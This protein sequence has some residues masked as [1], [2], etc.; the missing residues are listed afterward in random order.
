MEATEPHGFQDQASD[1]A[2]LSESSQNRSISDDEKKIND[3]NAVCPKEK[4]PDSMTSQSD[5]KSTQ[6][7]RKLTASRAR[8]VRTALTVYC[9]VEPKTTLNDFVKEE[10]SVETFNPSRTCVQEIENFEPMKCVG[11]KANDRRQDQ[12]ARLLSPKNRSLNVLLQQHANY[13]L[14][15]GCQAVNSKTSSAIPISS[16]T[17]RPKN[18]INLKED[19]QLMMSEQLLPK[20]DPDENK[21]DQ[22]R[23]KADIYTDLQGEAIEKHLKDLLD[24]YKG[25]F[26]TIGLQTNQTSAPASRPTAVQ[27]P[28]AQ[29]RIHIFFYLVGSLDSNQRF[30]TSLAT[31]VSELQQNFDSSLP[32]LLV[33]CRLKD[34][35]NPNSPDVREDEAFLHQT[36]PDDPNISLIYKRGDENNVLCFLADLK[37]NIEDS[38]D[39]ENLGS[40]AVM[41]EVLK[42]L[43]QRNTRDKFYIRG[44]ENKPELR[45]EAFKP[46]DRLLKNHPDLKG[47]S[48]FSPL[49]APDFLG[50]YYENNGDGRVL[51]IGNE[52][53]DAL[54]RRRGTR[55]D[56]ENLRHLFTR[57][58]MSVDV[59]HDLKSP[60]MTKA[61]DEFCQMESETASCAILVILTHGSQHG[62]QHRLYGVE[63]AIGEFPNWITVEYVI[64]M[65]SN[66]LH[67]ARKPRL[68]IINACRITV[69]PSQDPTGPEGSD[70]PTV[71]Q[72]SKF[73]DHFLAGCPATYTD[74]SPNRAGLIV[75]YST[76]PGEES[77]GLAISG[78]RFICALC[79]VFHRYAGNEDVLSM[80][81]RVNKEMTSYV[82]QKANLKT[83]L[84]ERTR[85]QLPS[86]MVET[87]KKFYLVKIVPAP[88][89]TPG[90][91]SQMLECP[92]AALG[93]AFKTPDP[94]QMA[95]H[96]ESKAEIHRQMC[97]N[98]LRD[99]N[100]KDNELKDKRKEIAQLKKP[101]DARYDSAEQ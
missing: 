63:A 66:A 65:L 75:G 53:F 93:C 67:L 71:I 44:I 50:D 94:S 23:G 47:K 33:F 32:I 97:G 59:R 56:C 30:S 83:E 6:P 7:P 40:C 48:N 81:S 88:D 87:T 9:A 82:Q 64:Q 11:Q 41:H 28:E 38:N 4:I 19:K 90:I 10:Y 69:P 61:V 72:S 35:E 3:G 54:N 39:P 14:S 31:V 89:R 74:H 77:R 2:S 85:H 16:Q 68:L 78:S 51:I 20:T 15:T 45:I 98:L 46:K 52:H 58:G 96:Q 49:E 86:W 21:W 27:S 42:K 92:L 26:D 55:I 17:T 101:A 13:L 22:I 24:Q 8:T 84:P 29:R 34:G 43:E 37:D 100:S 70:G 76:L 99:L 18:E 73:A 5:E 91:S 62:S 60:K 80:I 25:L 57:L 79:W 95:L 12:C 36:W 1:E